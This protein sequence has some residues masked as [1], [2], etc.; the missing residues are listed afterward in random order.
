MFTKYRLL[1]SKGAHTLSATATIRNWAGSCSRY[2]ITLHTV[3]FRLS[4]ANET[5]ERHAAC[6]HKAT[7]EP[8]PFL[9]AG[10]WYCQVI[11]MGCI[12]WLSAG[13]FMVLMASLVAG[14]GILYPTE[15][16]S[17]IVR[18]LDGIWAF[19]LANESDS[20]VGHRQ[21]WYKHELRK[22]SAPLFFLFPLP[23]YL[24]VYVCEL[25]CRY[26]YTYIYIYIYI[27]VCVCVC[28]CIRVFFLSTSVSLCLY[29]CALF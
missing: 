29:F 6:P 3:L 19:R 25:A 9:F 4:Q 8:V 13:L 14:E 28:V 18:S 27:Y 23:F 1:V 22:V 16:E 7:V 2:L 10:D 21:H 15:S 24:L 17:R 20:N 5:R 11:S 26:P 12:Q